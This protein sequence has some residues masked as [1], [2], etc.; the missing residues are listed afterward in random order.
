MSERLGGQPG[1]GAGEEGR[2]GRWGA[3]EGGVGVG[4]VGGFQGGLFNTLSATCVP[5]PQ[6]DARSPVW[7][8]WFWSRRC[9]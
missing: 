5:S 7:R 4:D 1:A 2:E 3:K 8:C 9:T 6:G